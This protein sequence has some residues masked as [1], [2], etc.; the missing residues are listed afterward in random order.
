MLFFLFTFSF[1]KS[2]Q[3]QWIFLHYHKTGAVLSEAISREISRNRF[4]FYEDQA[5][6]RDF[7]PNLE[8]ANIVLSHAGNFLFNWTEVFSSNY[9]VIH[10]VRDPYQMVLSGLLYHS[11][12]PPAE[13]W[14]LSTSINPCDFDE[15]QVMRFLDV[16]LTYHH[17]LSKE[18]LLDLIEQTI[19]LCH[20][21]YQKST[22]EYGVSNYH[23]VLSSLY[24]NNQH[25]AICL[26][27]CRSLLSQFSGAGGDLLRMAANAVLEGQSSQLSPVVSKRVFLSEFPLGNR[28][29][30]HQ[31]IS[32]IFQF[33]MTPSGSGDD[34]WM[35]RLPFSQAIRVALSASYVD[36][37]SPTIANPLALTTKRKGKSKKSPQRVPHTRLLSG[38][39]PAVS[40]FRL[41]QGKLKPV[42]LPQDQS[43]YQLPSPLTLQQH[44]TQGR[45]SAEKKKGLMKQLHS[46]PILSPLL[47]LVS[48]ILSRPQPYKSSSPEIETLLSGLISTSLKE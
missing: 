6:R 15:T 32:E 40:R 2:Q 35:G 22:I 16:L 7:H 37:A 14:L 33:L 9:R 45:I 25:Q 1:V 48:V 43:S 36:T 46:H 13:G 12:S 10:F 4:I 8:G 29:K 31:T 38:K 39:R 21:I 24:V 26:E 28:S 11:Q 3:Q 42:I 20:E 23:K 44:I 17:R 27:A 18:R 19:S 41:I 30:C 34:F 47:N 5:K